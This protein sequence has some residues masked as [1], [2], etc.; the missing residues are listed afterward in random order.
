ME[1]VL[2]PIPA[3]VNNDEHFNNEVIELQIVYFK[4]DFH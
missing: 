4:S 1:T 3:K 2:R